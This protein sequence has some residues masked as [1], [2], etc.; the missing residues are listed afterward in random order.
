MLP[1]FKPVWRAE[2]LLQQYKFLSGSL[3]SI[4]I[5]VVWLNVI[6][7]TLIIADLKQII[8]DKTKRDE[9]IMTIQQWN[10]K[11]TERTVMYCI[12]SRFTFVLEFIN[13]SMLM[14]SIIS[15]SMNL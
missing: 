15:A 6:E 3:W 8:E 12:K 4:P 2:F 9:L 11:N 13:L 7:V 1:M 5:I 10:I 14:K